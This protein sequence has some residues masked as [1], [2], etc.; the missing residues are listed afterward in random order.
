MFKL[1]REIETKLKK[2]DKT[3]VKFKFKKSIQTYFLEIIK[4]NKKTGVIQTNP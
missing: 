3:K 1:F 2:L 4:Y